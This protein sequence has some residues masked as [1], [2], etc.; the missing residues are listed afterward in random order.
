MPYSRIRTITLDT[1][2]KNIP[3]GKVLI[4]LYLAS[5]PLV[6][7]NEMK[8]P[9]E[10]LLH[11]KFLLQS[12]VMGKFMEALRRRGVVRLQMAG[13]VPYSMVT[14]KIKLSEF[15]HASSEKA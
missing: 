3:K 5:P 10:N 8:A 15:T 1:S 2:E 6:G 7:N 14:G 13:R 11:A 4:T 12:D 9:D